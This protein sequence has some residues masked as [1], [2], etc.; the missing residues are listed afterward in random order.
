MIQILR[1]ARLGD[2]ERSLGQPR[3]DGQHGFC[4]FGGLRFGLAGEH[5]H[6][7]YVVDI[8]LALLDGFGV[9][10]RV[11]VALRQAQPAGAIEADDRVRVGKVLIGA[12]AEKG[13]H[14]DRVQ[15][16]QQQRQFGMRSE[17]RRCGRAPAAAALGRAC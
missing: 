15:M 10:A 8:L 13:V 6:L 4:I 2:G 9:G 12:H 5:E 11:V 14:A 1:V 7:A 16:R 3:F 17:V